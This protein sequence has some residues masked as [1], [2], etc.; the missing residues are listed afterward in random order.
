MKIIKVL[1]VG[2]VTLIIIYLL[3][4][5]AQTPTINNLPV[6]TDI[7]LEELA[8]YIQ[9][10]E[11]SIPYLKEDNE[12]RVV[13]A[14]DS[15][16]KTEY[17]FVYLHGYSASQAEGSPIHKEIAQK[18]GANLYLSRLAGHGT[19]EP[20]P[21]A[22]L[23]AEN[24]VRSAKE[25]VAIGKLI[26]EKVILMSC[27]TGGTLSLYLAA[28][29]SEI[30]GLVLY[31]PNIDLYDKSSELVTAP[32]G[33]QIAR[34]VSGGKNRAFEATGEIKKY[35]T[36]QYRL[37]GIVQL[38]LLLEATMTSQ[39]F[40]Q[41]SQPTFVGYYYK[42]EELK[43]KVISV[44]RILEMYNQLGTPDSLKRIKAF[45]NAANHVINSQYYSKDLAG[46]KEE[47][48]YFLENIIG[49]VPKSLD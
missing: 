17:A 30:E 8:E 39:I 28:G 44:E 23:S 45:P 35:W 34:L 49:L 1:G 37:E 46:V 43:D 3:G 6:Q 41:V 47:T 2:L 15:I 4:P 40:N 25:A 5:Q 32:W 42:N 7:A 11:K 26:G 9:L 16:H 38:K 31:S 22:D 33:L 14:N 18:Y 13:W 24:L 27:S 48:S 19:N 20:E 29:D 21:F 10:Q 12:A 36:T